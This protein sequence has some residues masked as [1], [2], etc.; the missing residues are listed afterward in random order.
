[1]ILLFNNDKYIYAIG[2]FT[3]KGK[4]DK[5]HVFQKYSEKVTKQQV[6]EWVNKLKEFDNEKNYESY[7]CKKLR[8]LELNYNKNLSIKTNPETGN[9]S[10]YNLKSIREKYVVD[11]Y[12]DKDKVI[13]IKN[14]LRNK[15]I[16]YI[17]ISPKNVNKLQIITVLRNTHM[18]T[19]CDIYSFTGVNPDFINTIVDN[20]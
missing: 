19:M 6:T 1:M 2:K 9:I 7:R 5:Y 16:P 17:I 3:S 10:V 20:Y 13:E 12:S 14:Y 8:D 15:K 11:I 4:P 18:E